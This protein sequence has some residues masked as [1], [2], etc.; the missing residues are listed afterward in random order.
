[1][2]TVGKSMDMPAIQVR[3]T[4]RLWLWFAAGFLP[5]FV[6]M[7]VLL[8]MTVLHRS[9]QYA[10]RLPLWRYYADGIARQFSSSA[11][12]SASQSDWV[13]VHTAFF[14]LLFSVVG[15]SV[16]TAIGWCLNQWRRL[17]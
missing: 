17:A 9:G 15:G 2:K 3:R 16:L 10:V 13:L 6:A 5:V 12:G 7:L 8:H 4:R 14:H 11:F 1:M